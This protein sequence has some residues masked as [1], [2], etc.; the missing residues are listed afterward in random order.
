MFI[1]SFDCNGCHKD[2]WLFANT[3]F[4]AENYV[5]IEGHLLLHMYLDKIIPLQDNS[6]SFA[7]DL[8]GADIRLLLGLICYLACGF[9][10]SR[11]DIF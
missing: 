8:F 7:G 10:L 11:A 1:L 6:K 2:A 4:Q 9:Q 3:P 5:T